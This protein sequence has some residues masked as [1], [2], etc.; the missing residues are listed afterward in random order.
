[1]RRAWP[2]LGLALALALS[3]APKPLHI[4]DS[5]IWQYARQVAS[6]PLDP[7]GFV[8]FT[9]E[10]PEPANEALAPPG[11]AYWWAIA[12]R[13]FG[14]RPLL[15]KLWLLPL[16][17]LFTWSLHAL[18]RRFATPLELP[19][20]ALV[21]FSPLVLPALN[22]MLDIPALALSLCAF[23]LYLRACDRLAEAR[24]EAAWSL[25]GAA[26]VAMAL[27][28]QTKYTGLL[29]PAILFAHALLFRRLRPWAIATAIAATLFVGWE[30]FVWLRY[31]H[32]HFVFHYRANHSDWASKLAFAAPL[33]PLMGALAPG[34]LLLGLLALGRSARARLAAGLAATA[35]T[36]VALVPEHAARFG[37]GQAQA[38]EPVT[39]ALVLFSLLG[40]ATLATLACVAARLLREPAR[41]DW[42]LVAWLGLELAG[43]FAMSPFP[44][45]RR[46]LGLFLASTV[47]CGRLLARATAPQDRRAIWQ[48]VAFS[49]GLGL[50]FAAVDF[51][52]AWQTRRI[53]ERA[54]D[55][56]RPRSAPGSR[57]FYV[58]HW[59]FQ[60]YAERAGMIAAVDRQF[61]GRTILRAG[62]WLVV[63]NH[64]VMQ[65]RFWID[66]DRSAPLEV[67]RLSDPLP[68]RT[69]Y[70]YYQGRTPL[71]RH[72]GAR[73]EVTVHRVLDEFPTRPFR[74]HAEPG[75]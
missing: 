47:A 5:C 75:S 18:L 17:V 23:E 19:L 58:G 27:A 3:N 44:A 8:S 10:R 66:P 64:R 46:V 38:H 51:H 43:Y 63:P 28:S 4:D 36:L 11:L 9:A 1:V 60:Y 49:S 29:M 69:L 45:A 15:W 56:I 52:E 65:Q 6:A 57:I 73:M 61:Y 30:T 39:L 71:E 32:S 53:V 26:G 2:T 34:V 12:I 25:A 41:L 35:F 40:T 42:F 13:L 62:D 68:L 31:G 50:L 55:W 74:G 16:C 24:G 20:L 37:P 7:Y 72:D 67:I 21:V 33:V 59:G 14:D 48:A 70:C 54:A 22:L